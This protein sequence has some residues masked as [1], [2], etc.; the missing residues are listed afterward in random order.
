MAEEQEQKQ[1]LITAAKGLPPTDNFS[2]RPR[3][4]EEAFRFANLIAETDLIPK[5]FQKKPANVLVAIQLGMELGVPPMQA[6]QSMY[7]VN[8]RPAIYGDLLPAIVYGSGLCEIFEETGDETTATCIVKR[9]GFAQISRTFTWEDAKR[10]KGFEHGQMIPLTEKSTYKSYPKRMLQMRARAWAL[11]DAFP[12][13]LKGVAVYEEAQDEPPSIEIQQEPPIAIPQPKQ[14]EPK[15]KGNGETRKPVVAQ[16]PVTQVSDRVRDAGRGNSQGENASTAEPR[17][18]PPPDSPGEPEKEP[19]KAQ[20]GSEPEKQP[21]PPRDTRG[22]MLPKGAE[23]PKDDLKQ[24]ILDWMKSATTPDLNS[25]DPE[26]CFIRKVFAN[27]SMLERL[28]V[29]E[30]ADV[31]MAYD[32]ERKARP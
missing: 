4:F 18:E 1:D 12:D 25:Q 3:T 16:T 2:L 27:K 15:G 11:R 6:L 30:R 10:A 13:V 29:Q 17:Q 21:P 14:A 5:E 31:L 24:Q 22:R 20:A 9:R 7:V 32:Q 28:G 19:E 26:V 23:P 8:G